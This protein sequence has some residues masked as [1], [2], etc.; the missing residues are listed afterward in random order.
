MS[1]RNLCDPST[2]CSWVIHSAGIFFP[3]VILTKFTIVQNKHSNLLSSGNKKLEYEGDYYI[4]K[5]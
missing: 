5:Y 2:Y 3:R 1:G 4:N